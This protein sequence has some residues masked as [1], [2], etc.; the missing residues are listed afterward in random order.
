MKTNLTILFLAIVSVV[1]LLITSYLYYDT[2]SKV[3]S[4]LVE[5]G[6]VSPTLQVRLCPQEAPLVQTAKGYTDCCDGD[7]LDGK[8]KG[9]TVCTQSPSHDSIPT[10]PDYW[11]TYFDKKSIELCPTTLQNYFENIKDK[12]ATKGC[13]ASAP[14]EDGSTPSDSTATKCIVYNTP[15]ENKTNVNS[16]Y[17]YKQKEMV[18]CPA[19]PGATSTLTQ[20]ASS[21]NK[22][23][24]FYCQ[25]TSTMGIPNF[26]GDDKSYTGYLDRVWSNWK[27]SSSAQSILDNLCSNFLN[28]QNTNSRAAR[29]KQLKE[30]QQRRAAAEQ[31]LKDEQAKN[32]KLQSQ[33]QAAMNDAKN[34]KR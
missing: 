2:G 11:K 6:F 23:L 20:V 19:L 17:I 16:C 4:K 13:S 5:E 15:E 8:C 7:F 33:W 12:N 27:T 9:K 30:E 18:K 29:E 25:Y 14:I 10:C 28:A 3:S 26:C 24:F 21:G 22:F 34:C 32:A 31:A 1:G